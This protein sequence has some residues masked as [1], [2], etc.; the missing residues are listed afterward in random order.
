MAFEP[1]ATSFSTANAQILAQASAVA[2]RDPATCGK[3]ATV[4]GF[5]GTFDFFDNHDTQGFVAESGDAILV[6]FRGTQPDRAMDWF[7]DAGAIHRDWDHHVGKV[8]TGF[9]QALHAVWGVALAK[10]EVLPRRLLNR[11][12]KTI[13]M[14]GHSLGGALA[15]L[16]AAQAL[17]VS[18]VPVQGVYTFG[19]PRV[20]NKHFA[21]AV[22]G[23]IG[24]RIFRFV[25]DRDIVPR[26]PLFSTDYCHYG[27][28]T[29]Y[30]SHGTPTEQASAVETL[31][32]ALKFAA[33][34][35]NLG[36]IG[37]AA[38]IIRNSL[39]QERAFQETARSLLKLGVEKIDDHNMEMHYLARLKTSLPPL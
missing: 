8:H 21:E 13:W 5:T 18:N 27:C 4:S 39:E 28:Q 14:T 1:K 29:F 34:A 10:G 36:I 32:V 20:G 35:V 12:D 38:A 11:G 19:Q 25:N 31:A 23:R 17:F 3:W 7:V 6:A 2:Y 37:Q 30:D 26:V 9:Y 33:A 16:C 22:G 15:E 24:S